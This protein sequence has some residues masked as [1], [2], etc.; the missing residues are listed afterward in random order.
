MRNKRIINAYDSINPSLSDKQRMLD[1]ILSEAKLEEASRKNRKIREP[2]IYTQKQS[3][4]PKRRNVFGP[5]VAAAILV[6]VAG[7]GFS[8]L[9]N[10]APSDPVYVEPNTEVV[11]EKTAADHYAPVLKKYCQ[12]MD[13]GWTKEQCE[14]EGISLRMQAGYDVTKA[15]YALLD[16][17]GDGREELIIAEES[18]SQI[19]NI[20]DLYT[21]LE[22]GTP[23]Q[24]WVDEQNGGQCRLY[25]NNVICIS[26]SYNDVLDMSFYV[27]EAGQMVIRELLQWED[28]DTVYH[29]DGGGNTRQVT[30]K[31]GQN[32]S[33]AYDIQKLH[34]TWLKD[35]PEYLR[36]SDAVE[37]Y[38]PILEKY[39]TAIAQ[40]WDRTMC[41]EN[42]MSMLTPIE[43]E[44]EGLYYAVSDLD[45]NGTGE[46]VISE[47]P[48]RE[49]TDTGFIDIYTVLDGHVIQL[50][51]LGDMDM[52]YLC[53]DGYVKDLSSPDAQK[54][55]HYVSFWGIVEDQF[56]QDSAVY[57]KTDGQWIT[58]GFRKVG[59]A[60]SREEAEEIVASHKPARLDV[61]PVASSS[62]EDYSLTGYEGFDDI[63]S[64]YVT[65]LTE[66]WTDEQCEQNDI[67]PDIFAST[68]ISH[69]L[70]WCLRDI[71]K[72]G[73]EELVIS[74][75]VHLF[76]LYVMQP[77]NGG[78]GHLIMANGG[79]R[80]Q[81]SE[82]GTIE[83]SVSFSKGMSRTYFELSGI[84]L[85]QKNMLYYT[86]SDPNNPYVAINRYSYGT[87]ADDLKVISKEEAGNII[88]SHRTA[89]LTLTPFLDRGI[90]DPDDLQYYQ[91]L[92]ELYQTA[93]N[94]DWHP[95]T[96]QEKGISLMVAYRGEYYDDLGYA[97]RDLDGNGIDELIITDGTN[98]YD[99]YTI[100]RDEIIAPV[101]ILS[102]M[103]RIKYYLTEDNVIYHFGSS[104]AAANYQTFSR[105]EGSNL[106]LIEGYFY[107]G[108]TNP[109]QPWYFYDYKA[110]NVPCVGLDVQ[111]IIDSYKTV[112]IPFIAFR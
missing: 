111:A 80:Y 43:S 61:I 57:Q 53:E 60:V 1:A 95:T 39:R 55:I 72:N 89:E 59:V 70:G 91:P 81:L 8:F 41:V 13:E 109:D 47:Y 54:Y 68:T 110:N 35:I 27:L 67:S 10:R 45:G 76:D 74:D 42:G 21:T 52:R 99:L 46:L 101:N 96:C 28:E 73:V 105:L 104:S 71:D 94:E 51:S 82:D 22:D 92:L 32:I 20:W 26:Y 12:A 33:N 16:L 4:I 65:A 102:A 48:Y 78:P 17:D 103:E 64:K 93:L 23:I 79:E 15:G 11:G 14:I 83:Q 58:E 98:V 108:K 44:Y 62:N 18:T 90:F 50:M 77:H 87:G 107:D 34:L 30:S 66:N 19:D 56:M 9:M 85:V 25:E 29:T 75:G 5:L 7:F 3:A 100:V 37:Q 84:E 88:G 24:L 38:T 49:N 6:V 40:G 31:E 36:D 97:M 2:E 112:E 69:N 63:V 106:V 86:N